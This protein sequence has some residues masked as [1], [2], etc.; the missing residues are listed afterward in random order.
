MRGFEKVECGRCG[1]SGSYSWNAMHG[2]MC[3]GCSGKGKKLSKAGRA[4]FEVFQKI[5]RPEVAVEDL[6][7]GMK[8]RVR[9]FNNWHV[10]EVASVGP[11]TLNP[12]RI[13]VEFVPGGGMGGYGTFPGHMFTLAKTS[14]SH[15]AAWDAL[16]GHPGTV[17][18][19]A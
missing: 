1:G 4:A 17:E 7:P 8:L 3:Y 15:R 14:E 16:V 18:I 11:S 12:G 13:S 9:G 2:S 5:A 6:Q 19:T 10:V